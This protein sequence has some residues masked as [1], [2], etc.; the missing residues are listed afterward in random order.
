MRRDNSLKVKLVRKLTIIVAGGSGTRMG[1][2]VPKQFLPLGGRPVLMRTI[3]A[4]LAVP[5]MR[6]VLVLPAAQV[7]V[8]R[9]LCRKHGFVADYDVANGGSTRFESVRNGLALQNGEEVIGVHDGVRPLVT[10]QF[11]SRLFADAQTFGSA[12]PALPSVESV[13]IIMPDGTSRAED[14]ARVLMVQTPQ[15]FRSNLLLKAYARPYSPLFTDDASVVEADG[16]QV[17]VS[18]GLRGNIKL[19]TPDDMLSAEAILQR[20]GGPL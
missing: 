15:V 20:V 10:P 13:R 12:I 5:G 6:V 19:T 14:R 7:E 2:A 17:H 18:E 9:D 3:E 16:A 11:I 1:A 8:W 4:F